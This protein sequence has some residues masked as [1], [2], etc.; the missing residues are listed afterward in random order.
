MKDKQRQLSK[1]PSVDELLKSQHGLN[2]LD[3]Y[4]RRLVL[5]AIRETLDLQRAEIMR[6]SAP[7][8]SIDAIAPYVESTIKS[9]SAYRLKP[10]INATGV[11]I[12][13]NLGRSIL[14][15]K[16]IDNINEIAGSYSNLEYELPQ[17]QRGKRYSHIKDIL[18][19]ISGAEDAIAVNNNAAAVLLCLNTFAK[20]REVIVSRGELVEIGGSFRIP[21]VMRS[22]GAI[23]REVGTTNKTHLTDYKNAINENTALLL[24]VH[25]SNYRIIGFTEE[26]SIEEVVRLGSIHNLPVMVDLGSGCMIDLEKYGIHGEPSVQD[27]IKTGVDIVTFSGDK[28]LGGPQAG[29]ILG[30]KALIEEIQK[31][32]L[33]RAVRIDKLTLAALEATMLE[34]MDE[35]RAIKNI[36]TLMMLTQPVETIRLRAKKISALLKKAVA[37]RAKVEVM[38]DQSRA[39]GGSLPEAGLPTFVVSIMPSYISV[40][41][42]E[43][44]LRKGVP[45]VISRIKEDALILDARTVRDSEIKDL[46]K[47]IKSALS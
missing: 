14:S 26:V 27:I 10:L 44:R 9:L 46:I 30:R 2:W 19:E 41:A 28:L 31:N 36:P 21:D 22:S 1:I 39:G 29:I 35:E 11:I 33:T 45:P 8:L 16:S 18:K 40:S 13:T 12:H 20:G 7:E 32:P 6:G 38:T 17:G 24:K 3:S 15:A 42:L 37:D 47:N 23:L 25:P 43:E 5:K 4:P 34:Y